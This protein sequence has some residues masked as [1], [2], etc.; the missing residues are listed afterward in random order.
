MASTVIGAGE[1]AYPKRYIA[2]VV[3]SKANWSDGWE[4]DPELQ[5]TSFGVTAG[6]TQQAT[7]EIHRPYGRVKRPEMS[8]FEYY[9]ARDMQDWWIKICHVG[10]QG[11]QTAFVGQIQDQSRLMEG[12]ESNP[13]GKQAWVV[14]DGMRILRKIDVTDA[15]FL[16]ADNEV[17]RIEWVPDMNAHDKRGVTV[18]NRSEEKGPDDCYLY[19]GNAIWTHREYVEYVLKKFVT[20]EGGPQWSLTGQVDI[21]ESLAL[22]IPFS[23]AMKVSS[24]LQALIPVRYGVDFR[25]HPTETGFQVQVFA[26]VGADASAAGQTMPRNPNTVSIT[27]S[28][29]Y[30]LES[31][32]LVETTARRVDKIRVLGGRIIVCGSLRGRRAGVESIVG[33]W[34]QD[35]EADYKEALGA[36]EDPLLNDVYRQREKFRSVFQQFGAPVD[37]DLDAGKWA[38]QTDLNGQLLP[39]P[40][41]FQ[42]VMRRTLPWIPLKE[43]F[44][45]SVDPAQDNNIEDHTPDVKPPLAWIKDE[46]PETGD[47]HYVQCD[48]IGISVSVPQRDWG[49]VLNASPNHLLA[50]NH[51]SEELLGTTEIDPRYDYETLV[52]TLA[53][54][55]DSRLKLGYDVPENMRAGDGSVE[56]LVD[57]DAEMWVLLPGTVLDLDEENNFVLSPDST[58]VLRNDS[59]RLALLLAGMLMRYIN[60]RVRANI[61]IRGHMPWGDLIGYIL[62][63]VQQGD[64]LQNVGGPITSIEWTCGDSPLTI[65]KTGYA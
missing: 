33:K 4:Y 16:N 55:S 12:T 23:D 21:L 14:S 46:V 8:D 19:G 52:A 5:V 49:I 64:D 41:E 42:N 44:D 27:K 24:I 37:W 1:V 15:Y 62:D 25:V 51:W 36:E 54:E 57:E 56:T 20:Q 58:I 60:G 47:P 40:A 2:P 26:L 3:Y 59:P 6:S 28:E 53:F 48:L 63:V 22:T 9:D 32:Q 10:E 50:Y 31:V 11:L 35:I 13:S 18:G 39:T 45:Y 30:D 38:V 34:H 61:V 29:Q 17:K 7:C 43:N 65:I